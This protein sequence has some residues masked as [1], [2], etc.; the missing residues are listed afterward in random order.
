MRQ[1]RI[2]RPLRLLKLVHRRRQPGEQVA[3]VRFERAARER[4][5]RKAGEQESLVGA[6]QNVSVA[7]WLMVR[8]VGWK[9]RERHARS[10]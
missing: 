5:L 3:L 1:I 8:L 9:G 4:R 7:G 2:R 6:S 10:R